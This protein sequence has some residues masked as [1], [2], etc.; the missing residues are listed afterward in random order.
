MN[1]FFKQRNATELPY[2]EVYVGPTRVDALVM[3]PERNF[4]A[5]L[6]S[7]ALPPWMV[8]SCSHAH[9][10]SPQ[11]ACLPALLWQAC[12]QRSPWHRG[13]GARRSG[14]PP[15]HSGCA[16][17]TRCWRSWGARAS[18]SPRSAVRWASFCSCGLRRRRGG[19]GAHTPPIGHLAPRGAPRRPCAVPRAADGRAFVVADEWRH[20]LM[21][22]RN[23]CGIVGGGEA[24]AVSECQLLTR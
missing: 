15:R 10:L 19:V 13:C 2:V 24:P 1:G 7:E 14:N 12:R 17:G 6:E 11:P 18:G 8:A 16:S 5:P 4:R 23:P 22:R 21:L 20:H 9:A 3:Y